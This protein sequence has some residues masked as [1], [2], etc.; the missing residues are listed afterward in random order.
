MATVFP[1]LIKGFTWVPST[2]AEGGGALPDGETQTGSTIGV[3]A[4]GDTAHS[5]GNYSWFVVITGP[6]NAEST[7]DFQAKLSLKPGNYWAAIN[8]TDMLNGVPATS[9]WSG[10]IPFSIPSPIVKPAAPTG[11]TGA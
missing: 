4:D 9:A 11:F 5:T 8:Q 2:T 7:S 6:V 3:R 1:P 10:E